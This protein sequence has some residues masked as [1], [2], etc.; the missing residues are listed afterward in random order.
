MPATPPYSCLPLLLCLAGCMFAAPG[1]AAP[2]A[3]TGSCGPV[4]YYAPEDNFNS[5]PLK[6]PHP[7]L[8]ALLKG[9]EN[10]VAVEQRNLA[11]SFQTGYLVRP[12]PVT[13]AYW[14]EKAGAGGDP[15]RCPRF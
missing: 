2:G 4:R 12:C 5:S 8:G 6:A 1:Q 10:G 13:A 11:I 9:A 14:Y 7:L 3:P 15:V